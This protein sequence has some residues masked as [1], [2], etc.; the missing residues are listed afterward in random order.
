MTTGERGRSLVDHPAR[1]RGAVPAS[2]QAQMSA[3]PLFSPLATIRSAWVGRGRCSAS[4]SSAGAVSHASHSSGVVR[5]TGMAFGWIGA[6]TWLRA[7]VKNESGWCSP[8]T[9]SAFVPW[10]PVQGRHSPAKAKAVAPRSN[11]YGI[12]GLLDPRYV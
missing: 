10:A 9:G 8:S 11:Q 4:A 12:A 3:D 1:L 7:Q 5:M 2:S 6:T